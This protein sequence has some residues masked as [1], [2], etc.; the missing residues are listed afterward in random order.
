LLLINSRLELS[1]EEKKQI[2]D[3]LLDEEKLQNKELFF[4][5]FNFSTV[6]DVKCLNLA[7]MYLKKINPNLGYHPPSASA[8]FPLLPIFFFFFFFFF[9]FL[10]KNSSS[11]EGQFSGLKILDLSSNIILNEVPSSIKQLKNL[12]YLDLSLNDLKELPEEM[13]IFLIPK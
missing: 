3:S 2:I 7:R 8:P 12:S 1:Q 9:F 11:S 10:N 6:K 4:A 5:P 13:S